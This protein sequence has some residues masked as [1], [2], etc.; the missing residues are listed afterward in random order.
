MIK[1]GGRLKK[2]V[3]GRG[4]IK[5]HNVPEKKSLARPL[6]RRR[7]EPKSPGPFA[8]L[9]VKRVPKGNAYNQESS[10]PRRSPLRILSRAVKLTMMG[11]LGFVLLA[12]ISALLVGG[13]LYLSKSDYFAVRH[14]KIT[15]LSQ[16]SMEEVVAAAGLDRPI[17]NLT[18]DAK[19][20]V[21]SL[22]GLPWV[23]EADIS[24]VL[25]DGLLVEIKEYK[26]KALVSLDQL[27]YLDEKGRAFK[28]LDPGE[29]PDLPIISGF[30]L[31]ELISGGPLVQAALGEIFQLMGI[32]AERSDEFRL[33]SVSEFNYDPDLGLTLFTRRS[34]LRLRVGFGSYLEKFRRLGRVMAH[35]KRN[36]QAAGLAFIHLET[37]PRVVLRYN[38]QGPSLDS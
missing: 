28:K 34:G 8:S 4:R 10:K 36:G 14:L 38:N 9:F 37:P 25:P 5:P 32:L 20:A 16:L 11:L 19:L 21:R 13:F 17:N 2:L 33:D 3:T 18:F 7:R 26:P 22:S 15:G 23:E 6:A 1:P 24:R 27:Y 29:N 35:L 30:S 31:D 12:V